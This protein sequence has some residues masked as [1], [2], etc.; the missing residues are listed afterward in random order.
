MASWT[1]LLLVSALLGS[2][3]TGVPASSEGSAEG[4]ASS[5]LTPEYYDPAVASLC[6]GQQLRRGLARE[7]PQ[8]DLL[9]A[10]EGQGT[11]CW[12]CR[13][14]IQALKNMVG[15]QPDEN[16]IAKAVSKVC[17]KLRVS[18]GLCKN[19]RTKFLQSITQD[20]IDGKKSLEICVDIRMCKSQAGLM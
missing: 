1:L 19:L 3:G 14:M 12:L 9:T 16:S 20:I 17:R 4:L 2:P 15:E 8:G 11:G 18:K 7:G 10:T 6:E 13:K 5:S